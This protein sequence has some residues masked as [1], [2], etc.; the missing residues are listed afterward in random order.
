MNSYVRTYIVLTSSR[1]GSVQPYYLSPYIPSP[2]R[3]R[4]NDARL[5]VVSVGQ[6]SLRPPRSPP[7]T[8]PIRDNI[9]LPPPPIP[10]DPIVRI[11]TFLKTK[12]S[13]NPP[14]PNTHT[15]VSPTNC[16]ESM[17]D[18]IWGSL[19]LRNLMEFCLR[20]FPTP[21]EPFIFVTWM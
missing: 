9:S 6:K 19:Y 7:P 12:E 21:R 5:A 15:L 13:I 8:H 11:Y 18:R 16:L 14:P 20:N 3:T 1:S 17:H 2:P 4:N 10:L